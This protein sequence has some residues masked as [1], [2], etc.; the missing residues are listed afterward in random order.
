MTTTATAYWF[1]ASGSI[2]FGTVAAT[3]GNEQWAPK[4]ASISAT[5]SASTVVSMYN[6]FK[7]TLSYSVVDGGSPSSGPT[8]TGTSLGSAYAPTL[9]TTPTAYWFDATGSISIST[10]TSGSTERWPPSPAS[11]SATS[12]ASTVVSMYNQ[13]K[14]TLSYSVVDGGTPSAPTATGT[15][16]GSAY[17]PSLTTSATAYWF[18]ASSSITFSTSTGTNE[19]WAPKPSSVSATSSST[20]AVSMY[21]QF[22]FTLSYTVN[23]GG[24]PTAPTLTST[25]LGGSYTPTLT[26]TATNYWLDSGQSWS[27]TNP[28][29]GSGSTN[30]WDSS[31]TVSGTVSASS[32][33]TAGGTLIFT[34]Y[35][36]FS[37]T[38]S[39]SVTGGGSPTAPSLSANKFGTST[40][41]TLTTTATGYWYDAGASWSITPNPL[42]GSSGTERSGH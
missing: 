37:D 41:Q 22:P 32:P 16:L 19:Q 7:Q 33:T 39:Y 34:Y 5:S 36:Q 26:T 25:Q 24:S 13:Y 27:V 30:R 11:V 3:G 2:S 17:A 28:L 38:L 10:V 20:T 29:G 8:A 9:T 23:G 15:S 6:Q 4:T 35:N 31:Q 12:S 40:P 42:S 14:Q 21:N 18:D 1:D